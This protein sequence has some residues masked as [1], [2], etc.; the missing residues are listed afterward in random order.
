MIVDD[1]VSTPEGR[2]AWA[3]ASAPALRLAAEAGSAGAQ[4]QLGLRLLKGEGGVAKDASLAADWL[5]RAAE[6]GDPRSEALLGA[7]FLRGGKESEFDLGMDLV[8]SAASHGVGAA[9]R[10][11]D[12]AR[13]SGA[14]RVLTPFDAT[15]QVGHVVSVA[16]EEGPGLHVPF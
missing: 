9:A 13:G 1:T 8:H 3:A 2:D 5:R 10:V 14:E 4:A 12:A 6:Q 7:L 11:I 16:E 15:S